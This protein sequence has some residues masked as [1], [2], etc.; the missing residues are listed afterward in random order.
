MKSKWL[1]RLMACVL[2]GAACLA[3]G[4]EF[5]TEPVPAETLRQVPKSLAALLDSHGI[6]VVTEVNGMKTTVCEIWWRKIIPSK[7]TPAKSREILYGQIQ[8]G[9]LIGVLRFTDE[10]QARNFRLDVLEQPIDPGFYT[11]RY[12]QISEELAE[13]YKGDQDREENNDRINPFRDFVM[14]SPVRADRQIDRTLTFSQMLT[15]SRLASE[16]KAPALF[17]LVQV[18]PAYKDPT[19]LIPNDLGECALQVTLRQTVHKKGQS[20]AFPLSILV[21]VPHDTSAES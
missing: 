2:L 18:N 8:P 13:K 11:M 17:S 5:T 9:T 6:R 7:L 1:V 20:P 21:V 15:L 12:A 16:R 4:Q 10:D 3:W 19:L 14:L